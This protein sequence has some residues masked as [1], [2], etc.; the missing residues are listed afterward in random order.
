[1]PYS[2]VQYSTVQCSAL[3]PSAV[4]NSALQYSTF[5]SQGGGLF[6]ELSKRAILTGNTMELDEAIRYLHLHSSPASFT[7]FCSCLFVS[8]YCLIVLHPSP[9][10]LFWVCFLF[11]PV[12]FLSFNSLLPPVPSILALLSLLPSST[13]SSLSSLLLSPATLW[14]PLLLP[15]SPAFIPASFPVPYSTS[16]TGIFFITF[17]QVQDP[18]LPV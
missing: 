5:V 9:A 12:T 7:C 6:L 13:L 3:H 17:Y 16:L 11:F 10:S 1:M 18:A 2:I 15:P 4:E 8:F 14:C